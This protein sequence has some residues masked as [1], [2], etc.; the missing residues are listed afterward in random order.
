[1]HTGYYT[2]HWIIVDMIHLSPVKHSLILIDYS[3]SLQYSLE[4]ALEPDKVSQQLLHVALTIGNI[5]EL[6]GFSVNRYANMKKKEYY[7][8]LL[9]FREFVTSDSL[10]ARKQDRFIRHYS[11][12]F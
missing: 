7:S 6:H 2:N 4:F 10:S 1:M 9:V 12:N 3:Y 5:S 11:R 8:T